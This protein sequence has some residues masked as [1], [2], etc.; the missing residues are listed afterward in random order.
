MGFCALVGFSS[1]HI[2]FSG[3]LFWGAGVG[4][5]GRKKGRSRFRRGGLAR[6]RVG[7]FYFQIVSVSGGEDWEGGNDGNGD[8]LGKGHLSY[9]VLVV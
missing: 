6:R 8:D 1:T 7:F 2:G 4:A 9:F 3:G 5:V